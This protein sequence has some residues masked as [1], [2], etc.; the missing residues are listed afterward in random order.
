MKQKKKVWIQVFWLILLCFTETEQFEKR[1]DV[2]NLQLIHYLLPTTIFLKNGNASLILSHGFNYQCII[3][4]TLV[5][6]WYVKS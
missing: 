6:F 4:N 3:F 2:D 1:R 5:V